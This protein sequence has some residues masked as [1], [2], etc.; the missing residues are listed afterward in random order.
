MMIK[1]KT[2]MHHWATT[3]NFRS[4]LLMGNCYHKR[5][6]FYLKNWE[7]MAYSNFYGLSLKALIGYRRITWLVMALPCHPERF[8]LFIKS[9]MISC[10]YLIELNS[11]KSIYIYLFVPLFFYTIF[12]F[13]YN[14]ILNR[15]LLRYCFGFTQFA[16]GFNFHM[17][18]LRNS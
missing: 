15:F 16:F 11:I 2:T 4:F 18:W 6:I 12:F 14:L 9:N 17:T 8:V 1:R 3:G 7:K 13:F 5:N 10:V